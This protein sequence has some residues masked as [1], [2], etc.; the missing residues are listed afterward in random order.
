MPTDTDDVAMIEWI[1][2][3]FVESSGGDEEQYSRDAKDVVLEFYGV[4]T[5]NSRIAPFLKAQCWWG[6]NP[7]AMPDKAVVKRLME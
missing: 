6:Q 7:A 2:H 4:K 5:G 1:V 3:K